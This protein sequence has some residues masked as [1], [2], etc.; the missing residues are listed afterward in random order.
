MSKNTYNN[1][2]VLRA[3][4]AMLFAFGLVFNL[5]ITPNVSA[6]T[7]SKRAKSTATQ[8][9]ASP[10]RGQ[11]EGIKVHGHWTI[12]VRNPDGT[13]VTHREFENA[14]TPFGGQC[15]AFILTRHKT[16][17]LWKIHLGGANTAIDIYEPAE[18]AGAG[19]GVFKNLSVQGFNTPVDG[20]VKLSGSATAQM[21]GSIALVGTGVQLQP[22]DDPCGYGQFSAATLATPVNV[23][24]GQFVQV[25]VRISFPTG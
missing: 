25:T 22:C 17:G 18:P 23:S 8:P 14:L 1:S 15:L 5:G 13:L 3:I 11:Q 10:A 20:G 4:T 12:E 9:E 2:S 24:A 6:Q 19:A 7:Q 16:P 21:D